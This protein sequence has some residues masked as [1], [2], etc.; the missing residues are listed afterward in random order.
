MYHL[1]TN[2]RVQD[3]LFQEIQISLQGQN[4]SFDNAK[5][6]TM[7]YLRAV[8]K[9]SQRIMP[10]VPDTARVLGPDFNLAGYK[11]DRE[12]WFLALH[13][14]MSQSEKF[15]NDPTEYRPER[16]LRGHS[17]KEEIR[18]FVTMP[19]GHG[20]RMCIGRRFAEQEIKTFICKMVQNFKIEWKHEELGYIP[21]K[22]NKPDAPLKFTLTPR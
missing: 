17:L 10:V 4:Q 12:C 14:I 20:P 6:E 22:L 11:F 7:S 3:T 9:E 2:T 16:F 8:L 15:V 5:L 19:F 1:A 21:G 18:P 13:Q